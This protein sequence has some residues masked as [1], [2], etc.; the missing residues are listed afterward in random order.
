MTTLTHNPD[1]SITVST[2]FHLT[3]SMLEMENIIL[4][5]V[6]KLIIK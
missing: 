5:A 2:T 1:G 6:N 3:G 4:D